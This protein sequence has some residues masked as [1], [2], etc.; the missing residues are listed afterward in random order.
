[1]CTAVSRAAIMMPTCKNCFFS[2]SLMR[3]VA[4]MDIDLVKVVNDLQVWRGI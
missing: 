3:L 2:C 4:A 1:M